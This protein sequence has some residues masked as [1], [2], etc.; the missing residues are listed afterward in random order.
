MVFLDEYPIRNIAEVSA[1]DL[2]D[3]TADDKTLKE[4]KSRVKPS[5][6]DRGL[7]LP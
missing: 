5:C 6:A 2:N 1:Y 7:R 3:V 4:L